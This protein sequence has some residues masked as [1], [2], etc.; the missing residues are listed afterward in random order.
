M[1][2]VGARGS[3][4]ITIRPR[5]SGPSAPSRRRSVTALGSRKIAARWRRPPALCHGADRPGARPAVTAALILLFSFVAS[6][7]IKLRRIDGWRKIAAVLSSVRRS[8]RDDQ[9]RG[10]ER[11]GASDARVVSVSEHSH[12]RE[13]NRTQGAVRVRPDPRRRDWR[14]CRKAWPAVSQAKRKRVVRSPRHHFS[15]APTGRAANSSSN[16]I[17]AASSS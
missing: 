1:L 5:R 12:R 15:R 2:A 13:P 17:A 9:T 7:Q 6:G 10:R 11:L 3:G 16:A 14:D 8:P 4:L